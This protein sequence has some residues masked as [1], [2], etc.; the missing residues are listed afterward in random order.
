MGGGEV[1]FY[2][3]AQPELYFEQIF[4]GTYLSYLFLTIVY[5]FSEVSI[6]RIGR[7]FRESL[8]H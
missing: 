4:D 1:N 3:K 7:L 6:Y 5:K 8:Y 2:Q